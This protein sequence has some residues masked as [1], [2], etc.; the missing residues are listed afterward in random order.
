[1]HLLMVVVALYSIP[2]YSTEHPHN[3]HLQGVRKGTM[4]KF[5]CQTAAWSEA[6]G[7]CH[8]RS[9]FGATVATNRIYAIGGLGDSAYCVDSAEC[10]NPE[11]PPWHCQ[12]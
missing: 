9:A 5:D 2:E 11:T 10:F 7:L 1:M 3:L 6:A 4:F 12:H 8:N